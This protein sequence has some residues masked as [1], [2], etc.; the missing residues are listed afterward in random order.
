MMLDITSCLLNPTIYQ[1][2]Q[3]ATAVYWY[4]TIPHTTCHYRFFQFHAANTSMSVIV[5]YQLLTLDIHNTRSADMPR[6]RYPLASWVNHCC[7][8]KAIAAGE[9]PYFVPSLCSNFIHR[10]GIL[11]SWSSRDFT[12]PKKSM[13][14]DGFLCAQKQLPFLCAQKPPV[15]GIIDHTTHHTISPKELFFQL[16]EKL[17]KLL[18]FRCFSKFATW[19]FYKKAELHPG[20]SLNHICP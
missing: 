7:R 3:A 4:P 2:M 6:P 1:W 15:L 17:S 14:F 13:T 11:C 18:Q 19:Q 12:D 10:S 9:E 8:A 5:W 16:T 20:H